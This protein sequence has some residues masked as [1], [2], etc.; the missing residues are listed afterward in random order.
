MQIL[1]IVVGLVVIVLAALVIRSM[2]GG[3]GDY[4]IK[5]SDEIVVGETAEAT[6]TGSKVDK[7]STE[8]EWTSKDSNVISVEGDGTTCTLTAESLGRATI[9][10]TVDGETA[11]TR[12]VTVVETATGVTEIRV[13][14]DSITVRSGETYTI[15]ATVVMEEGKSP[16]GI[17]WSS[18]DSSVATVDDSGVVTARDVGKTIVKGVA[19][20]KTVEVTVE[21]VENPNAVPHDSTQDAGQGP[22][23]GAQTGATGGNTTGGTGGNA[24]GGSTG[25]TTGGTTGGT[26]TGGTTGGNTTGGTGGNASGGTTG[27][28]GD[29]TGGNT[30]DTTGGTTG[31]TTGE[32]GG[33][34]GQTGTGE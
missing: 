23:E 28:T 34:T 2:L 7:E 15:S 33:E 13:T 5:V 9:V 27:G 29:T 1:P 10:A 11:A 24:S 6:L 12:T 3:K 21:V 14:Q 18:A 4:E 20:D 30:G 16:A 19:G 26:T 17:K 8:V 32:T 22:E 31:G 25:S